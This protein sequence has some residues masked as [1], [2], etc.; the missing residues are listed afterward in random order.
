MILISGLDCCWAGILPSSSSAGRRGYKVKMRF[1][2]P[3]SHLFEFLFLGSHGCYCLGFMVVY[4]T[5]WPLVFMVWLY[6]LNLISFMARYLL[7][8]YSYTLPMNLCARLCHQELNYENFT[9]KKV[10]HGFSSLAEW[11]GGER[12]ELDCGF[13]WLWIQCAVVV[14]ENRG[15]MGCFWSLGKAA[16]CVASPEREGRSLETTSSIID[17]CMSIRW[18][19]I[20]VENQLW[21][22][23]NCKG[24]TVWTPILGLD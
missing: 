2:F 21:C 22:E 12:C 13:W 23:S 14:S 17:I 19:Y 16:E 7:S 1:L 5:K 18:Q 10:D 3:T 4:L 6:N 15:N 9:G 8:W 20:A 11:L 24:V